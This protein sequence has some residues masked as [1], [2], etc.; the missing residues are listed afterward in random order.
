MVNCRP[1]FFVFIVFLVSRIFCG[2]FV[3]LG[4]MRRIA[5]GTTPAWGWEGVSSWW[6]NPWTTYDSEHF[7][8]IAQNGYEAV[9]TPFF[10]LYPLLMKFGGPSDTGMAI[11]GFILS[12]AFF[13]LGLWILY[14]LTEIEHDSE[15]AR[16]TVFLL[17]LSPATM[18]FSAAY[19]ESLFLFLTVAC[20]WFSRQKQWLLAGILGFLAALSRNPGIF[21]SVSLLM[22]Y[23]KE[24]QL[25]IK[26]PS[27][28][29]FGPLLLPFMGFLFVQFYFWYSL[30]SPLAGLKSQGLFFRQLGWPWSPIWNDLKTLYSLDWVNFITA[31][32]VIFCILPFYLSW[33]HRKVIPVAYLPL[34]LGVI[35]MHLTY[36]RTLF[37]Q[38]IGSV[39]YML[40]LFP[41][42]QMV[43][44]SMLHLGKNCRVIMIATWVYATA[45]F[46]YGFG[47]KGFLG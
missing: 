46:S 31:F 43:A 19:S 13:F 9:R 23:H 42:I 27:W 45:I 32:N 11:V 6:L 18:F 39:R 44:L 3:Y 38:S 41:F 20:F 29:E 33:R 22:F 10:P 36:F 4:H 8:R 37:P 28:R 1:R 26:P 25:E 47:L 17:A 7:I 5:M 34:V 12:N 14:H 16:F 40:A 15:V 21:I 24:K 2:L 30:G 35:I